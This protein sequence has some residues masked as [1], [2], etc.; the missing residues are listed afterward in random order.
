MQKNGAFGCEEDFV[1]RSTNV[2]AGGEESFQTQASTVSKEVGLSKFEMKFLSFKPAPPS[3]SCMP[4]N[5]CT[6]H[7]I[8]CIYLAGNRKI[9]FKMAS[10]TGD[11]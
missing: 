3:A 9:Q 4:V 8:T 1:S 7:L 10:T 2:G 6:I 11:F 5:G